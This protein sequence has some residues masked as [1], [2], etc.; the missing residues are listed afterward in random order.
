MQADVKFKT[1]MKEALQEERRPEIIFKQRV[2]GIETLAKIAA[3][4]M[5]EVLESKENAKMQDFFNKLDVLA[6]LRGVHVAIRAVSCFFEIVG[7]EEI[8]YLI[9]AFIINQEWEETFFEVLLEFG[10]DECFFRSMSVM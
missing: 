4:K 6:E 1:I 10:I 9:N 3:V 7:L 2:E 5:I 8:A